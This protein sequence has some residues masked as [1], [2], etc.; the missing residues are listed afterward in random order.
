MET[1]PQRYL[2]KLYCDRFGD[3]VPVLLFPE[4][5]GKDKDNPYMMTLE[6]WCPTNIADG[7]SRHAAH[8]LDWEDAPADAERK[9][10]RYYRN[11]FGK[12]LFLES[13]KEITKKILKADKTAKF[14]RDEPEFFDGRV[15]Y[16]T[17]N[18]AVWI[19]VAGGHERGFVLIGNKIEWFDA[20]D[21]EWLAD[22]FQKL[23]DKPGW[24]P[25]GYEI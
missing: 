13:W 20:I 18:R 4:T 22:S 7:W 16:S 8:C 15:I 1:K 11:Q 25:R 17:D 5:Y 12:D 6:T 10:L 2:A 14:L 21:S 23:F 3:I 24:E 9:I 19:G